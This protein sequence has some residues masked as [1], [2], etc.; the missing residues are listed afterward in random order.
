[1]REAWRRASHSQILF[2][3]LF[4]NLIA[5]L[6]WARDWRLPT[7]SYGYAAKSPSI[8]RASA[9]QYILRSIPSLQK[10]RGRSHCYVSLSSRDTSPLHSGDHRYISICAGATYLSRRQ[11]T[12]PISCT[13]HLSNTP[14][15]H[16]ALHIRIST[17]FLTTFFMVWRHWSQLINYTRVILETLHVARVPTL[18]HTYQTLRRH[19]YGKDTD[20]R[21]RRTEPGAPLLFL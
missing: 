18:A 7:Y 15:M 2:L 6:Q 8:P 14:A 19:F 4:P 11:I 1:M 10:A 17:P 13:H 20:R 12:N 5:A 3:F 16:R 21:L 9:R